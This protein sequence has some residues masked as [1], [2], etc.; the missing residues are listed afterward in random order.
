MPLPPLWF[1]L[2][3]LCALSW[4]VTDALCKRALLEHPPRA[5][6]G[7]RWWYALPPLLATLA[8]VRAPRLDGEFWAVLA[9]SA[10]L[11]VAA[12]YLY[13]RAL[14][15]A[16]LS[17]TAP[18][19]AWTPVFSA[20]MSAAVLREI[21]SPAGI[22]GVLLVASGSWVL[23]A[24]GSAAGFGSLRALFRERGARLMLVVALIFSATSAL[25]KIGLA[26]SS[27]AFFGPVYV[28]A[29]AVCLALTAV[30]RGESRAMLLELKPNRWFFAIGAGVAAMTLLH[31][32]ALA[33]TKVA[34]MIAV[35]RSS[36][37]ASVLIGRVFFAERDLRRR[38][39][40]AAI[41]FAGVLVLALFP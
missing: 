41:M 17:L 12:M 26:H 13:L 14:T 11:E 27:A 15:L 2:A 29:L 28:A 25:G 36:L 23:Y 33:L 40:G 9:V 16:P 37:L 32:A 38:L 1:V 19:L 34:Y 3:L 24:R 21:P 6:L 35:K 10:P 39:P 8:L 7:A 30:V 4:A 31:F 18:L 5:V 20:V 22:A